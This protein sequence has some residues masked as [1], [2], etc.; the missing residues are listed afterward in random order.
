MMRRRFLSRDRH[1]VFRVALQRT[2]RLTPPWRRIRAGLLVL[3]L[4]DKVW[5]TRKGRALGNYRLL[6]VRRAIRLV[7]PMVT[8]RLLDAIADSVIDPAVSP[9]QVFD[10]IDRYASRLVYDADFHLAG[11]VYRTIIDGAEGANLIESLPLAYER[12]G[13]CLRELEDFEAA[14]GAYDHGYAAA[15]RLRDERAALSVLI[16]R[17]NL[18]RLQGPPRH[19]EAR[20]LL[21]MVVRR[22]ARLNAPE[23]LARGAH[24]RGIVSH[25][26]GQYVQALEYF[27]DA[28]DAYP[29]VRR[30]LRLL[31][32]IGR[33]FRSL[34]MLSYARDALLVVFVAQRGDVDAH[35]AAGINLIALAGDLGSFAAFEQYRTQLERAPMPARLRAG[36]WLEVGDAYQQFNRPSDAMAAYDQA[37]NV[38]LHHGLAAQ[39]NEAM[40]RL[41]G[42]P[43]QGIPQAD[44]LDEIPSTVQ[45]LARAVCAL[46]VSPNLLWPRDKDASGQ[47]QRRTELRRGRPRTSSLA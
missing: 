1:G 45:D 21:N 23:L 40:A 19:Q 16:A 30:R 7:R 31:G 11:H 37:A 27:A 22:A 41:R 25:E 29:D 10:A 47:P 46:R 18:L 4:L 43:A 3:Q 15:K 9:K 2:P 35:W 44:R 42:D 36:Y 38:T 26:Q 6:A 39:H 14:L 33:S 28:F 17:A 5:H 24:E 12:Y 20:R 32:D 34:G 8:R 13:S